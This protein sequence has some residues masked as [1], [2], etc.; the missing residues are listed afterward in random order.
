MRKGLFVVGTDTEAGKTV[1][2]IALTAALRARGLDATYMKPVGSD[3]VEIDGRLVSPDA[4]FASKAAGLDDPYELLNP[5]CL[6]GAVS[7]LAA[8]EAT[9]L[10]IDLEMVD[11]A[12]ETAMARHEMVIVEGVG[13]LLAPVTGDTTAAD[14]AQRAGLPC[15]VAARPGL[16]TINHTLMTLEGMERRGLNALGFCYSGQAAKEDDP[17]MPTNARHTRLF[18]DK[19]YFGLL[20]F[21]D[22]D[23]LPGPK[24]M[25]QA[26]EHLATLLDML[27]KFR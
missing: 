24:E 2:A 3:G 20:P 14:L 5:I 1:V 19:P 26:G 4:I 23:P 12:L 27:V 8:S 11:S 17:S 25:A 18:T 6:P 21:L 10:P 13:G 7:P 15:L 22:L 16:G 9:G